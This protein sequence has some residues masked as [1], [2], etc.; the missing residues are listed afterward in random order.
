ML[1]LAAPV[2]ADTR[3]AIDPA[4]TV[5]DRHG[6]GTRGVSPLA[7]TV[8]RATFLR[9]P[10]LRE[11]CRDVNGFVVARAHGPADRMIMRVKVRPLGRWQLLA[12]R[13]NVSAGTR[14]RVSN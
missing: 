14:M 7:A 1:G 4:A 2:A 8:P 13:T 9:E 11:I 10:L 3:A 12:V 5:Q 6:H